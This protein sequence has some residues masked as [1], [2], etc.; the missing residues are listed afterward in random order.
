MYVLIVTASVPAI[1]PL[2]EPLFGTKS[3]AASSSHPLQ[4]RLKSDRSHQIERHINGAATC[5]GDGDDKT[6]IEGILPRDGDIGY[7]SI[8]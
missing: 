3:Y 8:V 7:S 5:G 1:K 6:S 4:S 2:F